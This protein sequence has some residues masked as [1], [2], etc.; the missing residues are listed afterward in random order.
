MTSPSLPGE[1]AHLTVER[2]GLGRYRT[3]VTIP[4][5]LMA[6]AVLV[7]LAANAYWISTL[8]SA[9]ALALAAAGVAL[10]YGQLGLVSLCQFSLIGVGGWVT[11]RTGFA[12]GWPFELSLLSGG[13]A[14]SLVGVLCGLPALRLKGLYLAL[15]TLMLAG[16]F[17]VIINAFG[18]PDGGSGFFG[19]AD[20]SQRLMLPRPL[21]ATGNEAYF[22]YA[23]GVLALGLML[24]E[25]H[26]RTKPGRSWAMIRAGETTALSAGVNLLLYKAWAFALAGFLAGLAGG[27]LAAGVGQLDGRAFS[28]AESLNLFA[29]TVVGGAYNWF[30]AVIAGLLLRAVPSLLTDHGVDGYLAMVIFGAALLHALVTAPTGIAGQIA[31]LGQWL[32]GL[33]ASESTPSPAQQEA[34]A[35]DKLAAETGERRP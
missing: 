5:L 25:L 32:T 16:G 4:L 17:Q 27:V 24:I 22:L 30:G 2:P 9:A 10:L 33:I 1:P 14:A 19:R 23:V 7:S 34:P 3:L 21:L 11:L 18:F 31:G 15:V 12:F 6:G 26:R 35:S 28:A 8:T 20:A 29:L 13:I